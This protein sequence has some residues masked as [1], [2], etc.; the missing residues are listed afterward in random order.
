[1][2]TAS[3]LTQMPRVE[4]S[5]DGPVRFL[6]VS[7]LS[8]R[9]VRLSVEGAAAG[10]HATAAAVV[11]D[12]AE[13][14]RIAHNLVHHT[15]CIGIAVH[16]GPRHTNFRGWPKRNPELEAF[17][18]KHGDGGPTIDKAKQFIPG[19]NR[20][21][22]NVIH[23][24]MRT[25]DDGAA[26]YCH[27]GHHDAVRHNVVFVVVS[28]M[29]MGLYFDDEQ[30]DSIMQ[31][32]LV[33]RCPETDELD[34]HSAVIQLHHN[35]RNRVINNILVGRRQV[36]SMPNGY[37]GH[38]VDRN[39]LVWEGEP[40]WERADPRA[41][42]GPGDG[43]RQQGWTAGASQVKGN[44]WWHLEGARAAKALLEAWQARGHGQDSVVVDPEF[45]D[46]AGYRLTAESPILRLGF[47]PLAVADAGPR[48]GFSVERE[49]G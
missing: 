11:V 8:F 42:T 44:F 10:I 32:N 13:D 46:A 31:S 9:N 20:V 24:T 26:V 7:G 35:G 6:K 1:M 2:V 43:R 36:L 37:G 21:E 14:C 38:L 5:R 16:G 18:R 27:A 47:V 34:A 23:H 39:V 40:N 25:L 49:L 28:P 48:R 12:H 41:A 19:H 33:Y 22:K 30:M 4:G 45:G 29:G 17:W 15:P 3:W